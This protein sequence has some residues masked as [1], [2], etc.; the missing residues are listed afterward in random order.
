MSRFRIIAFWA[1]L[2]WAAAAV[3]QERNIAVTPML[4]DNVDIPERLCPVMQ[5]K[6]LQIATGNGYGSNSQ[7]FVLT[8]NAVTIDKAAV[9]TVPPQVTVGVDVVLY[10]VNAAEQLIVDEYTVSLSG[11]GRNETAAYT[12]ALKQL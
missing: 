9:P 7:E 1:C 3:A 10:V 6:L 12:A 8:A 4:I 11:I 5:Q 2:F